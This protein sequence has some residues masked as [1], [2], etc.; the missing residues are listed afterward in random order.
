MFCRLWGLNPRAL[1]AVGLKS[2]PLDHSGKP[3]WVVNCDR[4]L[5]LIVYYGSKLEFCSNLKFPGNN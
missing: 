5:Q 4:I 2:T 3:A 1:S